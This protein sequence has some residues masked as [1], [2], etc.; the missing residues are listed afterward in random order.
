MKDKFP[1]VFAREAK[2]YT[3]RFNARRAGT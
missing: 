3:D 2:F 1:E